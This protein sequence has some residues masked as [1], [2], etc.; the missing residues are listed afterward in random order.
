MVHIH[1]S[2][3]LN[4]I[5]AQ[6][7]LA[8]TTFCNMMQSNFKKKFNIHSV[9]DLDFVCD[10]QNACDIHSVCDIQNVCHIQNVCYTSFLSSD[11]LMSLLCFMYRLIACIVLI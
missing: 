11:K 8:A 7:K 2:K 1:M 10:K 4:Y 9:C 3:S 5:L 6:F